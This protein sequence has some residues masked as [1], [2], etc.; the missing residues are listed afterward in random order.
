MVATG[1]RA[2]TLP[3]AAARDMTDAL[4]DTGVDAADIGAIAER[5]RRLMARHGRLPPERKL[6][7]ALDVKRH[8]LR[9]A[10]ALLREAGQLGPARA[11]RPASPIMLS[12]ETIVRATSPVEVIE[13]RIMVEPTF[14]RHAALRASPSEI[15][16]I[17]AATR[18]PDGADPAAVDLAF[19]RAV[20]AAS[21]NRLGAEIYGLIRQ[22]G[23][24]HRIGVAGK[25]AACPTSIARRDAEHR[26]VA[27]AIA[28]RDPEEAERAMRAHLA[29]V[30]RKIIDHL[31]P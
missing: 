23:R 16:R 7:A 3:A 29:T 8:R 11:G 17:V 12:G 27:E 21:R 13:L 9:Q 19:H 20:A 28:A 14:A 1:E 30:Y 31:S 6:A 5:V 10:L 26:L 24:D 4:A 25:E 2:R 15:D 18:T 22:V